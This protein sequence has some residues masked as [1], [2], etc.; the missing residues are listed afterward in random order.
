MYYGDGK[1]SATS[2]RFIGNYASHGGAFRLARGINTYTHTNKDGLTSPMHPLQYVF[3]YCLFENNRAFS[4]N[5]MAPV[6]KGGA[7]FNTDGLISVKGTLF[8]GNRAMQGEG[9]SL[10]SKNGLLITTG[11]TEFSHDHAMK[12]EHLC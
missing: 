8:E 2:T 11:H 7:I 10:Y 12:G 9:G 5:P 6:R 1:F 4:N 3:D